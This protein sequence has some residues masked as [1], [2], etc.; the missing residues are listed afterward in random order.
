QLSVGNEGIIGIARDLDAVVGDNRAVVAG[1]HDRAV[2]LAARDGR[3]GAVIA[4]PVA[5]AVGQHLI[6]RDRV[7]GR[8]VLGAQ[9]W[10]QDEDL[11]ALDAAPGVGVGDMTLDKHLIGISRPR[12]GR[13]GAGG[14][15]R[16][17]HIIYK[18]AADVAACVLGGERQADRLARELRQVE[19]DLVVIV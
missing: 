8:R 13:G 10:P 16:Q 3:A 15:Y 7:V 1:Y 5:D 6:V 11:R 17:G 19:L 4:V 18:E 2:G 9:P 14:A 12:R